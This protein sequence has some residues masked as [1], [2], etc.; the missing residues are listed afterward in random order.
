MKLLEQ[1]IVAIH[2]CRGGLLTIEGAG[3]VRI[4]RGEIVD[5]NCL[6]LREYRLMRAHWTQTGF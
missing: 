3:W 2:R 5:G 4:R 6:G 1:C